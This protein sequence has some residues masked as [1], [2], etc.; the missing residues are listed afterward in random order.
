VFVIVGFHHDLKEKKLGKVQ[1]MITKDLVMMHVKLL[2]VNA[3]V[4]LILTIIVDRLLYRIITQPI[5]KLY[6]DITDKKELDRLR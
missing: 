1:S 4:F 2:V 6:F 3:L 5:N